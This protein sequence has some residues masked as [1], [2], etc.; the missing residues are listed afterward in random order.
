MMWL[1]VPILSGIIGMGRK[2]AKPPKVLA[3]FKHKTLNFGKM[4]QIDR[5]ELAFEKCN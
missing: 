1:S 4:N 3:S 5:D 2:T